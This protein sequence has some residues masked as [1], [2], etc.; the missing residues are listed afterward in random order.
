MNERCVNIR[1]LG[2]RAQGKEL[3]SGKLNKKRCCP[4]RGI[5]IP[6]LGLQECRE[7][8]YF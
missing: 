5:V 1:S 6:V 2:P 3:D 8:L 4:Q 7:K